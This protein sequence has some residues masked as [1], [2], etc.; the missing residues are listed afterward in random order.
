VAGER[1]ASR[2]ILDRCARLP[3]AIAVVAA[4]AA[5]APELPLAVL[6]A[7]LR[8]TGDTLEALAGEDPASDL[9]DVFTWSYRML[10]RDA[11]RLLRLLGLH[12]GPDVAVAAV[13]S[14]VGV[15][16]AR[17]RTALGELAGTSLL[18]QAAPDRYSVHDLVRA[19]AAARSTEEDSAQERQAAVRRLL[20]HY[21]HTAHAA[22]LLVDPTRTAVLTAPA[23]PGVTTLPVTDR[24]QALAWFAQEHAVLVAV[25]SLAARRQLDDQCWQLA[26]T[27]TTALDWHGHWQDLVTT[28]EL[29]LDALGRLSDVDGQARTRRDLGRALAQLGHHEEAAAHL[30]QALALYEVLGDDAGQARTH[31]SLGWLMLAQHR[32]AEAL[33]HCEREVA[34][35]TRAGDRLW[36]ARALN[37]SGWVLA[38]L[39]DHDRALAVCRQ[40]LSLLEGEGDRHGEAGTW[41]S[42]GYVHHQR[43]DLTEAVHCYSKALAIYRDL[44]DRGSEGSVLIHL[45]DS[46]HAAG[47]PDS[48]ERSWTRAE[49]LLRPMDHPDAD[50][51]RARLAVPGRP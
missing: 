50:V 1:E 29:A 23:E 8:D 6:A 4:G 40:A 46:Q 48:A 22:V 32:Y 25:V 19:F 16:V 18:V 14:L 7:R 38:Q 45:G 33:E 12:P 28:Q 3:L 41:D 47:D 27:L 17:A 43:G 5:S 39:G 20:D 9:R 30:T 37:A 26:W 36:Q 34:L 24:E 44:G 13:A 51:A 15:P 49:S 35:F 10:S 42:I 21:L 31:H 2:A 11:A